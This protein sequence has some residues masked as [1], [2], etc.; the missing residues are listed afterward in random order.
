MNLKIVGAVIA[1]TLAMG[2]SKFG[3]C[4]AAAAEV[5]L[6]QGG[7]CGMEN[8]LWCKTVGSALRDRSCWCHEEQRRRWERPQERRP[9][10]RRDHDRRRDWR[11]RDDRRDG[12]R[13]R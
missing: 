6:A 12:D 8:F 4:S 9:W 1:M 7:S 2:V 3:N 10:W 13:R 11:D 5:Q